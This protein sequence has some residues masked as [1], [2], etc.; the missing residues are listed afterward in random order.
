[1]INDGQVI[2][3]W[4]NHGWEHGCV[5]SNARFWFVEAVGLLSFGMDFPESI[6][7]VLSFGFRI[8]E[9]AHAA[10]RLGGA[11][12]PQLCEYSNHTCS[13]NVKIYLVEAVDECLLD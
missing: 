11:P 1:V 10:K 5:I 13:N 4:T 7:L 8:P 2:G 9:V 6:F 3:S 12:G